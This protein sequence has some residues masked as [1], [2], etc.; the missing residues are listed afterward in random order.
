MDGI[1]AGRARQCTVPV[2]ERRH[3]LFERDVGGVV[4]TPIRIAFLLAAHH[5]I[6]L[7]RALVKERRGGVDGRS[8]G[9]RRGGPFSIA[10]GSSI[11]FY[12]YF[13]FPSAPSFG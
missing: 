5:A 9:D 10:R 11:R 2:F 8:D 13:R 4:I 12:F 7:R 1:H 3:E 6:E